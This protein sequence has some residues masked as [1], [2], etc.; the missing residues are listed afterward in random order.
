M[1]TLDVTRLSD[2][3]LGCLFTL[4]QLNWSVLNESVGR[5]LIGLRSEILRTRQQKREL[6]NQVDE[7]HRKIRNLENRAEQQDRAIEDLRNDVVREQSERAKLKAQNGVRRGELGRLEREG[8]RQE[9]TIAKQ[10]PEMNVFK[11]VTK[12]CEKELECSTQ[13]N[14]GQRGELGRLRKEI[15]A[16]KGK[17]DSLIEEVGK[18]K[19]E[20]R[21]RIAQQDSLM[22]DLAEANDLLKKSGEVAELTNL[23]KRAPLHPE[24]ANVSEIIKTIFPESK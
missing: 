2:E 7:Q 21:Q 23:L 16:V 24:Q 4:E 8:N 14:G 20:I 10:A 22:R 6:E 12:K 17:R 1:R 5:C 3:D 11:S 15:R 18:L 9:G 13:A 19:E